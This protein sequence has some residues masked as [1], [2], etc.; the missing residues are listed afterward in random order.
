MDLEALQERGYSRD[1]M[2][3]ILV[4]FIMQ[5]HDCVAQEQERKQRWPFLKRR[6]ICH[7]QEEWRNLL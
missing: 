6:V 7:D 4:L 5:N 2:A 1:R 3:C